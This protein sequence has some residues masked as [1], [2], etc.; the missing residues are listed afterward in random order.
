M[1]SKSKDVT[2][3]GFDGTFGAIYT[4]EKT[5]FTVFSTASKSPKLAI[6]E[7]YRDVFR[8]EYDMEYLGEGIY[9]AEVEKDLDGKFYTYLL[10]DRE[11]TDPYS[12]SSSVNSQK[13]AIIDLEKTNPQGFLDHEIP[14]NDWKEAILYEV[15]VADF[16][17]DKSSGVKER[18]KF[19]GM[20]Q[21]D[22]SFLNAKTGLDHLEELG[23][24]HV[25][26][27][28]VYDFISVDEKKN[29]VDYPDNYNWG[30]DPELYN[31]V[32][33]SYS[34]NPYDPKSRIY[35][36]KYL[37][38]KLH[39]RGISVVLDVVYNH[40]FKTL[41]SNFNILAPNY[42]YRNV[43][44]NFSN[45]S[46]CGNEFASDKKY[47]RK[48]IIDSLKYW[49]EEF[50]VDGFR[51]DL[52]A[53]LDIDTILM[54]I[55]ELREINPNIIIY[56]EPW[57]ALDSLLP[58]DKQITIGKQKGHD[59]AI[60]NPFYRDALRGDNDGSSWGYIQ[61]D[62]SFKGQIQEGIAGSIGFFG[63]Y[64]NFS[65]PLESINYF[66]AH[67]NLIFQ[68]KL[69]K[70]GID[71][72]NWENM[73]RMAFSILMM[74][75]GIPFFHAGNE[76]LRDKKLDYNSYNSSSEVNGIDWSLKKEYY[77]T[78]KLV[79]DLIKFRKEVG[80]F[81]LHT[82][83]EI[84]ES[85]HFLDVKED[86]IIAFT[87]KRGE[88]T[89]LIVHNSSDRS[90]KDFIKIESGRLIWSNG[91]RDDLVNRINIDNF[92]SNVYEIGGNNEF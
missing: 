59:F 68:D 66:N 31:T 64:S 26:L 13:S 15:H 7:D 27:L 81:N 87:I 16:T 57:M 20:A 80:I 43:E 91:F 6:Y 1:T 35:E 44:G 28:P 3:S 50:K 89:Y 34:T 56:G 4:K 62:Y 53:I 42:Y 23:V 61:G 21:A 39:E 25:H 71:K 77:K 47:G 72:A 22:T 74:S 9:Y 14:D 75:Q 18:G 10:G 63:D 17:I 30:Y 11:V 37:V 33:G 67:D 83:D 5:Q 92:T 48:F 38:Q 36:L 79:K 2:K 86:Y 60:F 54:A 70:S 85:I 78:F 52:M 12:F 69:V 58:Y 76:F 73:T 84:L 49:V 24:T 82:R 29:L 8:E 46:G 65:N 41:D 40:T 32:E 45:A 90:V 55:E 51:F 19:L 88:K